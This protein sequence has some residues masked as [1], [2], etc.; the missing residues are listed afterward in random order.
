M[1]PYSKDQNLFN[2]TCGVGSSEWL[3]GSN[4]IGLCTYKGIYHLAW[5]VVNQTKTISHLFF[6]F[7][8]ICF[9]FF[10]K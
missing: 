2:A 9:F 7:L 5:A 10:Q 8:F 6:F 1:S 4:E 3:R